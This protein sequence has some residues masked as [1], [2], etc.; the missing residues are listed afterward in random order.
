VPITLALS[1][2]AYHDIDEQKTFLIASTISAYWI[3]WLAQCVWP[4]ILS[5]R[6]QSMLSSR[7]AAI[8][9]VTK[10]SDLLPI[11]E[12]YESFLAFAQSEFNSEGMSSLS[13]LSN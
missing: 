9:S 13:S 2:I 6:H 7:L 12:G 8:M 3:M 5:Y 1:R 10:L 4:L 11:P